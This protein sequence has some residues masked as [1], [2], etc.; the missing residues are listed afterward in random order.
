MA[1][2]KGTGRVTS[3]TGETSGGSKSGGTK[4]TSGRGRYKGSIMELRPSDTEPL[5][6]CH[7]IGKHGTLVRDLGGGW[8]LVRFPKSRS[9]APRTD[10]KLCDPSKQQ[11]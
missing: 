5:V 6:Y 8:G 2:Q 4:P 7:V 3:Q 1:K 9:L 10:W 11:T